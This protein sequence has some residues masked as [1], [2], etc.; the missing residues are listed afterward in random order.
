MIDTVINDI[1]QAIGNEAHGILLANKR[2]I[3]DTLRYGDFYQLNFEFSEDS[4]NNATDLH[5][6]SLRFDLDIANNGLTLLLVLSD[7]DKWEK[8]F[9]NINL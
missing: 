3:T 8:D 6:I 4:P 9:P 5:I 1:R 2:R 7:G